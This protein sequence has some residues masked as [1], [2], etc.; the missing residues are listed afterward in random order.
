MI[1]PIRTVMIT[2]VLVLVV[3]PQEIEREAANS[4]ALEFV[5][6]ESTVHRLAL[7]ESTQRPVVLKRNHKKP[8]PKHAVYKPAKK[9]LQELTHLRPGDL[10]SRGNN[11]CRV[12]KR[13]NMTI[14]A[15]HPNCQICGTGQ[16]T[17]T[18]KSALRPGVAVDPRVVPLGSLVAFKD[19][20]KTVVLR[21]D[22]TGGAV[23][24]YIIDR[25]MA[26]HSEAIRYG[27][28]RKVSVVILQAVQ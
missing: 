17:K 1:L 23:H 12:V 16:L 13:L 26:S 8:E 4:L 27:R 18:G 9:S 7:V 20:G 5:Q 28:R 25:R 14:T 2:L 21:A 10:V 6:T 24:G 11:H 22:D 15:Y 19:N 3:M